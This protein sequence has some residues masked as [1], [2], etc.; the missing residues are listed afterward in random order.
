MGGNARNQNRS[1][2]D[3]VGFQ[4]IWTKILLNEYFD[5]DQ[6]N[7]GPEIKMIN[8]RSNKWISRYTS[9]KSGVVRGEEGGFDASGK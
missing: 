5:T 7:E 3:G 1:L 2:C 9:F 6:I 4:V 8:N